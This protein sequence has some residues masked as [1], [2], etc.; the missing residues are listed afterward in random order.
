MS[1]TVKESQVVTDRNI[2]ENATKMS[3]K[4]L[5]NFMPNQKGLFERVAANVIAW[6]IITS[7]VEALIVLIVWYPVGS[8]FEMK[9]FNKYKGPNQPPATY[10]DALFTDMDVMTNGKN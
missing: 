8:Y 6:L 2:H 4:I 9:T 10:V 7:I 1:D 3:E 5:E